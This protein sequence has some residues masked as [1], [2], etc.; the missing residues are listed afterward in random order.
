MFLLE[1][2]QIIQQQAED[3]R[4]QAEERADIRRLEAD[5]QAEAHRRAD[6]MAADTRVDQLE[7]RLQALSHIRPTTV[8]D[9]APEGRHR[10]P[11]EQML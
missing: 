6:R 8:T 10:V 2:M 7:A 11:V 5:T 4:Q 9:T 3:R 1:Q